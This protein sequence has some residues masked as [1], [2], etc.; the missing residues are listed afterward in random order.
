M[1]YLVKTFGECAACSVAVL[2]V[3]SQISDSIAWF[4][5]LMQKELLQLNMIYEEPFYTV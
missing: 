3:M 2:S 4:H 1:H 5:L